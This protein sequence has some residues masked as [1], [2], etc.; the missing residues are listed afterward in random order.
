MNTPITYDELVN[1]LNRL[2]PRL[3]MVE[4]WIRD[5]LPSGQVLKII[6]KDLSL[7]K[8]YLPWT[9]EVYLLSREDLSMEMAETLRGVNIPV[10]GPGG[11]RLG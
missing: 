1:V 2:P 4:V 9:E 8:G 7:V 5:Y 10:F 6:L 3:P 11:E